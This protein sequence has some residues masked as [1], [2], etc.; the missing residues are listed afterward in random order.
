MSQQKQPLKF[1]PSSGAKLRK[2]LYAGEYREMNPKLKWFY[3][4]WAGSKRHRLDIES[5]PQGNGI[6]Y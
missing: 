2:P 6:T 3:N 4:P 5:D 1:N